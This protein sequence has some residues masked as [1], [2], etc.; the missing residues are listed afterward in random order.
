M[1]SFLARLLGYYEVSDKWIVEARDSPFSHWFDVA[2]HD[3]QWAATVEL[4]LLADECLK[5]RDYRIRR[6]LVFE[7]KYSH[8]FM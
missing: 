7:K 8:T 3:S 2:W 5:C 4:Q 1:I 6:R